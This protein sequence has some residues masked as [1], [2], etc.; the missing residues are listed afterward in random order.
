MILWYVKMDKK[1][2]VFLAP[3]PPHGGGIAFSSAMALKNMVEKIHVTPLGF[4]KVFPGRMFSDRRTDQSLDIPRPVTGYLPWT[5][6]FKSKWLSGGSPDVLMMPTWTS[7]LVPCNLIIMRTFRNR[8]PS[9]EVV[10]WCH[11]V[12]GHEDGPLAIRLIKA[13]YQRADRF[14]CHSG[15]EASRLVSLGVDRDNILESFLPIH[16]VE[17]MVSRDEARA[18]LGVNK[19]FHFLFYGTMR[20]YKGLDLLLKAW[21]GLDPALRQSIHLTVAGE[22]W[23][24]MEK[25]IRELKA[26]NV[27]V[28][29][30]YQSLRDTGILFSSC[31]ALIFPY[32]QA[33]A[34]G[35]LMMAMSA[36][37]PAL[38]SNVPSLKPYL[39]EEEN[40]LVFQK[41]DVNDLKRGIGRLADQDRLDHIS[42]NIGEISRRF[43]WSIWVESVL[44]FL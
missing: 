24:G 35:T 10:L 29:T 13:L 36:G 19:P 7:W 4:R 33:T 34:S 17:G 32:R 25:V 9:A 18:E 40:V 22:V 20:P 3:F 43:S 30:G 44:N 8:F 5:W 16:P 23:P 6:I 11:N 42:R 14:I 2:V 26:E 28:R 21:S 31:D 12:V 41:D 37:K 15:V 27:D 39:F 38:V 1:Q